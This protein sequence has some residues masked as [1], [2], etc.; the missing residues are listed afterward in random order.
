MK[1]R[2]STIVMT[3]AIATILG[4]CG[5]ELPKCSDDD[6]IS[7]VREIILDQ[8]GGGEGLTDKEIKESLKIEF[9]RASTF[10]EKIKKYSC[11]AKLIAGDMYQLPITYESQLDDKNQHIVS[12][13]GIGR[14]D[15][16]GVKAGVIEGIK[17][18]RAEK[19]S[20]AKPAETPPAQKA[21]EQPTT[22]SAPIA[23]DNPAPTAKPGAENLQASSQ[24]TWT[25]SFD[26]TKASTFSEKAVCTD[27][28]LG[29]LDGALSQNY[30]Y[31][32][33]S[34]IGDG[35]R[36][37]LK[38]TQKKWLADRN[39]CTDN[40]CLASSYRE[41]MDEICEYPVISGVHPICTTSDEIK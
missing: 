41:R 21:V 24:P 5:N 1:D 4:G 8:I 30:K 36:N 6:T 17:K 22:P 28:L 39:K 35:A 34:D 32:L 33:A 31:M 37:D 29:K 16:L 19:T 20:A 2:I 18:I 15:L 40:Q 10:D 26:C 38:A 9:P 27:S 23:V 25:P 3:T 11:E 12:V 7:L 14:G 13:G